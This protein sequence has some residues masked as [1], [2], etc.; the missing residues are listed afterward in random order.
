MAISFPANPINGQRYQAAGR[1]YVYN[2]SGDLWRDDTVVGTGTNAAGITAYSTIDDLPLT[3]VADGSQA[4]ILATNRLYIWNNTGWYQIALI[5]AT[6]NITSVED[7]DSNTTPF[8][9]NTTA[10]PTVITVTAT[11]PEGIPLTYDFTTS[12]MA[13]TATVTR[14]DNVFTV[15]PSEQVQDEGTFDITFTA[16]DGVNV[17]S[18]IATF[19]LS[20]AVKVTDSRYTTALITAGESSGDNTTIVDSSTSSHTLTT[21]GTT[22]LT[23]LSPYR[24]GGYSVKFNN[25]AYL[26][27]TNAT[28]FD[29]TS[30]DFTIECFFNST[31]TSNQGLISK[32]T[33]EG[34]TNTDFATYLWG[35]GKIKLWASDGSAY[36]VTELTTAGTY[37][38]GEWHHVAFVRNGGTIHIYVDGVSDASVSITGNMPSTS[39]TF[40]IGTD[41]ST[42][43]TFVG[44]IAD[45]RINDSTAVYTSNFTPPAERLTAVAGTVLLTCHLPYIADSSSSGHSISIDG[46]ISTEPFAPYDNVSYSA[47]NHSGS[48]YFDGGTSRIQVNSSTDFALGTG[49]FTIEGWYN[50]PAHSSGDNYLFDIGSN[51]LYLHI[52]SNLLAYHNG[53]AHTSTDTFVDIA[54]LNSWNHIAVVRNSGITNVYVNGKTVDGLDNLT[55]TTDWASSATVTLMDYGPGSAGVET[56]GYVSDFRITTSAVY[57][58]EF[59]PSTIP[60]GGNA[61]AVL[62]LRTNTANVIDKSQTFKVEISNDAV[63][64]GAVTN[65]AENSIAFDGTDDS[66]DLLAGLGTEFGTLDFT[67]EFWINATA[68]DNDPWMFDI[69]NGTRNASDIGWYCR[70]QSS[71]RFVFGWGDNSSSQYIE[72]SSGTAI[73]TAS[74]NHIACIRR[75]GQ[76]YIYV[77]GAESTGIRAGS[78]LEHDFQTD[79]NIGKN[80]AS[81]SNNL[82]G[83][84]DDFRITKGLAR[85]TGAFT[86]PTESLEG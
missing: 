46:N 36:I 13:N 64:S 29:P 17:A 18:S 77:N 11:D 40:N 66:I 75:S 5:N 81:A 56:S 14:N 73:T 80:K 85:Y 52:S 76:L 33:G 69:T 67:I 1:T 47:I 42:N 12:G 59:T 32:R 15:T 31:A 3:N 83:Y 21:A 2:T 53:T 44:N 79:M 7:Q 45:V 58:A 63:S 9:L 24:H 39:K 16:S 4:L 65:F 62:Y 51:N 30:S 61:D 71:G 35:D 72:S 27:L 43:A 25:N 28:W 48:A 86:P 6:P 19:T 78:E 41:H 68:M 49:D 55:D 23:S 38:D 20:F 26:S 50:I 54:P 74:W 57:T 22:Y 82:N 37:N 10:A 60:V 34:A 8:V 70:L 84:I